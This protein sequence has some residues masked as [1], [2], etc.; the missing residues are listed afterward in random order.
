MSTDSI[1]SNFVMQNMIQNFI[2]LQNDYTEKQLAVSSTKH[3]NN[4]AQLSDKEQANIFMELQTNIS[5]LSDYTNNNGTI[6]KKLNT[7][8]KAL[9]NIEKIAQNTKALLTQRES[10]NAPAMHLEQDIRSNLA[11]I[12]DNLNISLG[13]EHLFAGGSTNTTAVG[14]IINISNIIGDKISANYYIGDN[15]TLNIQASDSLN[16]EYGVKANDQ[17]FQTLIGALHTAIKGD[18]E[19]DIATRHQASDMLDQATLDI[20]NLV[21]TLGNQ[22][23]NL[24]NIEK[25]NKDLTFYYNKVINDMVYTDIPS[26]MIEINNDIAALTSSYSLLNKSSHLSLVDYLK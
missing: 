3:S 20:N 13:N 4:Y 5:K 1:G 26:T 19:D 25:T 15:F 11:L 18:Q 14:D 17:A 22:M 7:M 2:N 9:S 12:R 10:V 23:K 21:S 8:H 16:I 6:M 24:E